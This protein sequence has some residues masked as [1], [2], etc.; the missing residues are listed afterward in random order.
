MK[1]PDL[2]KIYYHRSHLTLSQ[3]RI[4][5]NK[6]Y[7]R[8]PVLRIRFTKSVLVEFVDKPGSVTQKDRTGYGEQELEKRID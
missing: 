5:V 7:D 2:R 1:Y 4:S 6:W 8:F 3:F